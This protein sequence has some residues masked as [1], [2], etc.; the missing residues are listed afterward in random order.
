MQ[1]DA[2]KDLARSGISEEAATN[3]GMY[4]EEN[5]KEVYDDFR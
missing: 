5:A 3:A 4:T 1:E 2:I